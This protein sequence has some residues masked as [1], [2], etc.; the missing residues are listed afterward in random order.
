LFICKDKTLFALL[1]ALSAALIM[2]R[3]A[4]PTWIELQT[5]LAD[6][7]ANTELAALSAIDERVFLWVYSRQQQDQALCVQD[8]IMQSNVASPATLHKSLS[9]LVLAGLAKSEVD[10]SDQRRRILTVTPKAEK[11]L[12]K[13]DRL[14]QAWV[15]ARLI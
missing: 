6:S 2:G 15:K 14:V 11:L 10:P 4:S 5:F 13:L 12:V 8:V 7:K 3:M 1:H 9:V